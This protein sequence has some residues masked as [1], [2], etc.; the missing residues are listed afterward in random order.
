MVQQRA[1]LD[2]YTT[3]G[4]RDYIVGNLTMRSSMT[5]AIE[6]IDQTFSCGGSDV[7]LED[8]MMN[9]L[10]DENDERVTQR[11]SKTIRPGQQTPH[12]LRYEMP[13]HKKH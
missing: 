8:A 3:T 5:Y 7:T 12:D 6:M 4:L 10:G 11:F 13:L 2:P 9:G 1:Q